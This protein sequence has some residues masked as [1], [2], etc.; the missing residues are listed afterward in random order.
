MW[1]S[2]SWSR[3]V[4]SDYN[5]ASKI[6][7]GIGRQH[8]GALFNVIAYYILAL[9]LGI[10]MAFHPKLALGLQGLWIGKCLKNLSIVLVSNYALHFLGQVVGLFIVGIGEYLMVWLG[11]DWDAE[12]K[13]GVERNRE[14][15]RNRRVSDHD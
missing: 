1:G 2:A 13:K 12:I 9:P 5:V 7:L 14:E 15:A 11:T 6:I 4:A 10:T 8:L 3:S